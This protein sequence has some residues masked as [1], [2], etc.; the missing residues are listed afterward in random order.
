MLMVL[1]ELLLHPTAQ[2]VANLAQRTGLNVDGASDVI[3]R[4]VTL[5]C[6][7]DSHPQAGVRLDR[8]SIAC[9][10]DYLEQRHRDALGRRVIVY[11]QTAST[12]DA[13]RQQA[14]AD[15]CAAHG[16]IVLA[17]HQTAGRGRLGS[18]WWSQ[19]GACVL[20]SIVLGPPPAPI[21]RITLAAGLAIANVVEL[22][23]GPRAAL[24]WPNDVYIHDRKL[25]GVLVERAG[26]ATVLGIGINHHFDDSPPRVDAPRPPIDLHTAGIEV[27]RL[28][29]LDVLLGQL[30]H[31]LH[32]ITDT[33]LAEQWL[34]RA[35]L[36]QHRVTALSDGQRL[37]G[38]VIDIDPARGLV[39]ELQRG[40][41]VFLPAATTR[42]LDSPDP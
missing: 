13:A 25:A 6:R 29:V 22:L 11:E 8:A 38:R 31:T 36:I 17:D 20:M 41:T 42:L 19:P 3:D 21:D 30:D 27:D 15:A 10:S 26:Q 2:S 35:G 32:Q 9:W 28:R 16:T 39:V 5:G 14:T 33:A 24:H 23:G 7:F 40:P 1:R 4:L 12:Q 18:A 34:Q 37:T